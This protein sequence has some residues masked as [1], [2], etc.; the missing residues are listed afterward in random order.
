[1]L[2]VHQRQF[3]DFLDRRRAVQAQPALRARS[4][5]SK[6]SSPRRDHGRRGELADPL[7]RGRG[8][9][10]LGTGPALTSQGSSWHAYVVDRA[11]VVQHRQ[12]TQVHI[13]PVVVI[14]AG[15]P[16]FWEIAV[17]PSPQP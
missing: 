2:A 11:Q 6:T 8:G 17:T 13:A 5:W 10:A 12:D 16:S 15:S 14:W 7:R 1:M 4:S 3:G 9:G